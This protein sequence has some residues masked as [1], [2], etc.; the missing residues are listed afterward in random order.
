[1]ATSPSRA[2]PRRSRPT[3]R[4]S[5]RQVRLASAT[6]GS[7]SSAI[8]PSATSCRCCRSPSRR[9]T[10]GTTSSSSAG[11]ASHD[12]ITRRRAPAMSTRVRPDLASVFARVPERDG[13]TG[14]RLARRDVDAGVRRDPRRGD[15]GGRAGPRRGR[16]DRTSWCTRT[17]SRAR[18]SRRSAR[19]AA[20]RAP[21]DGLARHRSCG[22]RAS[23]SAGCGRATGCPP[24]PELAR[25]HRFGFLTTRPP[26]CTTR[27]TRCRRRRARSAPSAS[28]EVAAATAVVAVGGAAT[29]RVPTTWPITLGTAVPDRAAIARAAGRG[30]RRPGRRDRRDGRATG[31]TPTPLGPRPRERPRRRAYVP[32]S[33]PAGD[34]RRCSCSTAGPGRCWRRWRRACRWSMLPVAADQPE[35]AD[36][37]V[38]AGVG[39][40]LAGRARA[41]IRPAVPPRRSSSSSH[42][43]APTRRRGGGV[44]DEIARHAGAGG[45]CSP[46][47]SDSSRRARSRVERYRTSVPIR[48]ANLLDFRR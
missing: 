6:C 26:G 35:N 31:S 23:R 38:A 3:G 40:T 16:G 7:R 30:L 41:R 34:V 5:R 17:A 48:R 19:C 18:G 10:P 46:S 27:P 29:R 42:D 47:S 9:A 43:P 24:D 1:M 15:G 21:G 32:M 36:R 4:R 22:C 11:P 2:G 28:D 8:P 13:L 44:R 45:P 14:R 25:W 20:R 12:A 37:C 33:R 39:V